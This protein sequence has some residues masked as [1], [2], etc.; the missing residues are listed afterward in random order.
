MQHQTTCTIAYKG[1]RVP[2]GTVI[3]LTADEAKN[4]GASVVPFDSTPG[5]APEPEPEVAVEDM[6]VDQLKDKAKELGLKATGSK[7]DLIERIT[8]HVQGDN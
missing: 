6:S 3:E 2:T 1:D 7:A 4:F 5:V 8:L